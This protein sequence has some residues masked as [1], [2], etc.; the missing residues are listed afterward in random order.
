LK[1]AVLN[2]VFA[3]TGGGA[4]R[5]SM[6]LVEQLAARH[7]IHVF[8]QEI[9]H[10]WPNVS[11][12]RVSLPFTRP[13]WLNQLWYALITW[14][15]TRRG[16]DIVHSHE[17][18]W[19]GNV[20]TMHVKTTQRSRFGDRKGLALLLRLMT[21]VLSPRLL[22]YL[23]FERAR[24]VSRK[25]RA[26]VAVSESLREELAME[27]PESKGILHVI[28]PGVY[29]PVRALSKEQ[30]RAALGLEKDGRLLL[31]VARDYA[32]KGLNAL[33]LALRDIS[34][35]IQLLVA[36]N[37]EEI[38]N[39]RTEAEALGISSRV[40]FLGALESAAAAYQAADILVHPT[41]EDSFGMV[42]LEA[43]AYRLPV[44]VSDR[45]YCGA[46]ALLT[47]YVH[48]LLLANP[49]DVATLVESIMCVINSPELSD[50]LGENG[51]CLAQGHSWRATALAYETLYKNRCLGPRS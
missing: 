47:D 44:I 17:N 3:S 6:A 24:M 30:A 2:R 35:E 28:S 33:L 1:I 5:Y 8:A 49:R 41:L 32:R 26:I 43:M 11:Y 40:H 4:E 25:N 31:F 18:V 39:F 22:T 27:Y 45:N 12:H 19:H 20:Q 23:L 16:F 34:S 14:I 51:F 48:A 46:S 9:D 42:V 38:P 7:D 37:T 13:R 15:Q 21:T 36:G 29:L 50:H 10:Q